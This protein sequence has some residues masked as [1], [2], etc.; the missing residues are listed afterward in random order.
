MVRRVRGED[1]VA[2]ARGA[3]ASDAYILRRH[4]LPEIIPANIVVWSFTVGTLVVIEGALSFLGL[5]VK[6][7]LPSWGSMLNSGTTFLQTAWWIALWPGLMLVLTVL[8]TNGVGT[9]L[10]RM[11]DLSDTTDGGGA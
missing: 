10:R 7:P 5:G 4:I 11:L 1:H 9:G 3:G 2:A 6:P 8:A